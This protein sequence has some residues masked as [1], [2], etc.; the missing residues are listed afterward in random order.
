MDSYQD[1]VHKFK[2]A[3]S[4]KAYSDL[5]NLFKEGQ[6]YFAIVSLEHRESAVHSIFDRR[7]GLLYFLGDELASQRT[8]NRSSRKHVDDSLKE[9]FHFLKFFIQNF[10]TTPHF[11]Q[12]I[13]QIKEVCHSGLRVK[14]VRYIQKAACE[15]L[16]QLIELFEGHHDLKLTE[17]VEEFKNITRYDQEERALILCLFGKIVKHSVLPPKSRLLVFHLY[18]EA[19][20]GVLC[21]RRINMS[22]DTKLPES[23]SAYFKSLADMLD[24][25][26]LP[27]RRKEELVKKL[28]Y[29]IKRVIALDEAVREQQGNKHRVVMKSA[30]DLFARHMNLFRDL[31]Y[32]DHKY[33]HNT[34]RSLSRETTECGEY[35]RRALKRFYRIIGQIL[36]GQN[37]EDS[38]CVLLDFMEHFQ[39]EFKNTNLDLTT[40]QSVVYGFSQMAAPCKVHMEQLNV[41]HMYSIITSYA[42]PLCSSENSHSTHIESVCFYQKALSEILCHMTDV[43]IEKINVLI[44]LSNYTIKRFPDLT[45]NNA[46][47]VSSLITIISNLATVSKGLLQRYLDSIV[48][49]GIA[50]S[51]SHTLALDA[52][53]QRELNNLRESPVCYKNYLSLWTEL[54]NAGRYREHEQLAQYVANTMTDVCIALINRLNIQVKRKDEDTVLSD[55][56]LTQSAVNQADFR[57]FANLVD[58]YVDVVDATKPQLFADT[59]HRF[60]YEAVRLSY[61]YPLIS[62]FYKLIRAGMKIFA[63]WEGEEQQEGEEKTA[64]TRQTEELLSKYLWHTLDLVPAFSNELLIACLYLILNAPFAYV[65]GTLSRTL[66]AFKIAFT[67]GLGNLELAYNALTTLETWTTVQKEKR[68]EQTN[69]LLRE[70][71]AYLEPYLRSTE[72][73]VE[74]SQDLMMTRRRVRRVDI[75]DTECT[76]RNFQRRVL[77]FLGSLDH[78]LFTSF[79]HERASH[80]TGATWDRKN[81]LKF[82]LPLPDVRLVIYFDRMLPRIIALARDSSDRRTKIAA[83]EVLHSVVIIFVGSP[84]LVDHYAALCDTL[85]RAVLVLGCD[86]DEVVCGLFHPLA[87]QLMHW[88]SSRN[89]SMATVIDSL[90]DGLTDNSNPA[91]REFSGM[92]LAEFT[93]WTMRQDR[94]AKHVLDIIKR[95]NRLALHPSTRKRVAAA[96][97]FNHLYVILRENDETVSK[98]WLEIFYCFV[99]SLDGYNDPSISN[100]LA[101]IEKVMIFKAELLN[102]TTESNRRKPPE[103]DE[104]TLTCALYWLL[105]RC[106][107]L[108]E[109]C[110]TKCMEL[111][112]N[113]SRHVDGSEQETTQNFVKTYGMN[114]LN[115]I[116]LKGAELGAEDISMISNVTPLLKALD[117]YVWLIDR[118][119]FPV[120]SLFPSDNVDKQAIFL[121]IRSFA[122]QFWR[123]IA[124]SSAATMNSRELEQLQTL[125][126]KVLMT[127]LNFIQVLLNININILPGSL[128]DE[129][130][131][132]LTIKCIMHPRMVGF[133]MKNIEMTDKLPRVLETL[134]NSMRSKYNALPDIFKNCLLSST[135]EYIAKLLDLNDIAQKDTCDDLTQ[136]VNGL[137]LLK[138]CDMLD[139][140]VVRASAFMSGEK[141]VLQIFRFLVS[142]R[143]G[144][145]TCRDL[146]ARMIGYLRALMEFQFS[147]LSWTIDWPVVVPDDTR[148]MSDVLVNLMSDNTPVTSVDCT[149]ITHGEHFLNTFKS[150]IFEF[151]L[152]RVGAIT[153]IFEN[154]L[155]DNLSLLL[156][157]TEDLLLFLK[158]HRRE[159]RAHVD[160]DT[161]V[162]AILQQFTHLRNTVFN[163][164]SR[165]ERLISI[166]SIVVHLKSTPTEVTQN[167]EFYQW[168]RD[169]LAENYGLEHKTK[170]LKNFFVCLTDV[171]NR[172][173]L[174]ISLRNLKNDGRSLCSNLSETSVN[175]M[176]VIDCFETLLVLLSTTKS[177]VLLECVIHFAAGAG[178]RL[179]DEKLEEHLRGYYCGASHKHVVESLQQTYDAFK[180]GNRW[181]ETERLDILHG[182]LLPAFKVCDAVAI[183]HFFK[184]N[185]QGLVQ[186]ADLPIDDNDDAIKQKIVSKIG[187]FQLLAIMFARVDE[188]RIDANGTTAQSSQG[189]VLLNK[190]FYKRLCQSATNVRS[191]RITRPECKELVR[192]LHCFAYNCSLAAVSLMKKE[193]FYNIFAFG[194]DKERRLWENIIDCSTQY[195]LGQIF[196]ENPKTREITVNIKSADAAD[197]QRMHRYTH[198]Y[199][200]DLSS[201]TLSEDINAYDFNKCVILPADFRSRAPLNSTGS[202]PSCTHGATSIALESNDF[203]EHECMPYICVLL[204]HMKNTFEVNP[205]NPP[206][207][208]KLFLK[209]MQR[210]NQNIQLFMLTII[211]NTEEVFKPYAKAVLTEI[212]A[213]VADYLKRYDLNY[214]ITDVLER[215]LGWHDVAVPSNDGKAA[216]QRLFEVFVERALMTRG[217]DRRVYNYNISLIKLMVEKWCSC[218]RVSTEFL[219]EK[220]E[221]AGA[222]HLI[223]VLLDNDTTGEIVAKDD[224]VHSLLTSLG[225]WNAPEKDETPLQCCECLGLYLRSLDSDRCDEAERENKKCEVKRK[226]FDI[227][228]NAPTS[229]S[230]TYI[231]KQV[232]RVVVLCRIYPEVAKDYIDVAVTGMDKNEQTSFCLEIFALAIPRLSAEEIASNLRRINLEK[233]LTNRRLPHGEKMALQIVRDMVATVSPTDLLRYVNL[234]VPYLKDSTTQ[235]RELVYDLLMRTH[236]RY[237]ADIAVD[238]DATVQDLLFI[239]VRNLLA[240]L[241]D[242]SPDLQDKILKFWTEETSLSTTNSK[243]RLVKLLAMLSS[244]M[245]TEADAFA[246]FVTLLMLQL[247]AGSMEYTKN[248]FDRPVQD[249]CTFEEYKIPVSWRQRNLSCVT[250]M[251]VD[252]LASQMSYS[253]FSQSDDLHGTN[254]APTFSY[255][256]LFHGVP[257]RSL[258]A[259]QEL[260]F[261]PTLDD[262]DD[263]DDAANA[264]TTLDISRDTEFDWTKIASSSRGPLQTPAGHRRVFRI[265]ANTSDVGNVHRHRKIRE[266]VQRAERIKQENIRQRSSVKLNRIGDFPDIEISHA[267]VIVSLQQLIKLDRL[268]CKDVTVILLDSL[269]KETKEMERPDFRRTIVESLQ[270]ILHDLCERD[271][272]FNAVILET[273]L[274]LSRDAPIVDCDPRDIV[275]TSKVNHLDAHGVLL[276]ERSLLPDA[277]DDVSSPTSSKRMRRH[278]DDIRNEN[279]RKWAQ[280]TSLYK[281]LNDV[282]VVLSIFRGQQS[283]GQDVQEAALAEVDGDWIR[284]KKAF[285]NAY[286]GTQD[287]SIKE[288]CLQGLLEAETN[289]CDWSAI[290]RLVKSRTQ[291]GNLSNMW[292]DPWRD[293]VIPYACDA[294]V[295]MSEMDIRAVSNDDTETIESW[296]YDRDKLQHLMPTTGENLV[297][298]QL[299]KDVKKATDLLNE[300]LD[301]TGKQWVELSPLCTELRLRKLFKLQ[302]MSDLD[303]SLKVLRLLANK[304]E[305]KTE[306]KTLLNFW[307]MKAPGIRDNLVQWNKLAANRGYSSM[308]F[309]DSCRKR[310]IKKRLCQINYQLQLGI[311]DAALNQ[312]HRYVAEKHLNRAIKYLDYISEV[313]SEENVR[314]LKLS[315]AWLEARIKCLCADV[316]TSVFKK[317]SC[318]TASWESLHELLK[319]DELDANTSTAIKEH[320]GTMASKIEFL[321]RENDAF[322]SELARSATILRDIGMT[323]TDLNDIREHLLRYSLNNL[324]SCC[325]DAT[326]ANVGE[327]Y[328]AL[329]RH[330]YGRLT[331]TDAESDE[332]FQEF[333]LSTLRSMSHDYLEATHYF[334]CLLRPE[335]LRDDEMRETF[336]RECAKLRPWLFLRWR[337]LLFSHLAT[338]SIATAIV[339]I[340]ERLAET[341]PDAIAY[342]YHL[343][344]EKNPGILHD[345]KFQRI[346]SLLRDKAEEYGL[347]VQAIRYVAQPKL[348]LRYYL[349]EAMRDLSRGKTIESTVES[350]LRKAYPDSGVARGRSPQPGNIFNTIAKYKRMIEALNP[351]DRDIARKEIQELKKSTLDKS[352]KHYSVNNYQTLKDYS[353]FLHEYSGGI[354]IPGQY[355]GDREPMPRRHVRLARFETRVEVMQSLRKPIRIGMVGDNG[356][357]YKF[358]VKFGEDLTID[359]GLQQLYSTMNRT[360]RNDPGCGQRR[361]AIDTYEVIPLSSSFGLIQWIEDTR[362]LADLINFTLSDREIDQC[363]IVHKKYVRWMEGASTKRIADADAY[364]AAVSKYNQQEVTETMKKLIKNTRK[365][366]LRDAFDVI[367]PSPEC[368]VT[369]RRNFVASYA[370]M[371]AAHWLAGVGDRH[372][373][374]TLVHVAT[375][376][377]L[378][379]DFGHAFGSG[380]RA[381]IPELVPFR[382]TPQILELLQPF[383]ERDLLA[384]I[385]THAMRALRDD[386]GPILACMDIFV[387][388]PTYR[389]FNINDAEMTR[390]DDENIDA[391]LKWSS[392]RNI[393]IVAKKLNGIHPSIITLE[394]LKEA[395]NN[396]YFARYDA[397]VAGNDGLKQSRAN[398]RRD[399]LTP[400]E[401]VD[402]LLDQAKDYNILGRMYANWKPWL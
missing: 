44:K 375:G 205:V 247:A 177:M 67:V 192:L 215:L 31:L 172:Q 181:T 190:E 373:E 320:I 24:N 310:K 100:A 377:C 360:L 288:H 88:L 212:I 186:D 33:W 264:S 269:I 185:V 93:R 287:L 220:L 86:P 328:C 386:R 55:V 158:R 128:W 294:F 77:L 316:E 397:I 39:Q 362:S 71:I 365:T 228:A 133:N 49:D 50:W 395:H 319:R 68:D 10:Y 334:P 109:H 196:K 27:D 1:F 84:W 331:S 363:K 125:Q 347:F 78:D 42:L 332:M 102:M 237:S 9:A 52:E 53:L 81:L 279:T 307:L 139:Q 131:S 216:A 272:S 166:Y 183:E 91:L 223:L 122:C 378:G 162:D 15:A 369:L 257:R 210:N 182:F 295:H 399:R 239:S 221:S 62:G 156:E 179:F 115:D 311:V 321:S 184:S 309:Q 277:H 268:I 385:M 392:K 14:G 246:P 226:I 259:T 256:R 248:I 306:M 188:G 344:V 23:F 260:Q 8:D 6:G 37:N 251:F 189:Q 150:V 351:N 383:T 244:R 103:F 134:L 191:I 348:Y 352:S 114:R 366:A 232:K 299:R 148:S 124:E 140:T 19:F 270:R 283:F 127:M 371:C 236:K 372:L 292:D 146:S 119:L 35:G 120:E 83:C 4:D 201:C 38:K 97:A 388:K 11:V 262:D 63:S 54:L 389:P 169:Q 112:V 317:I 57:V 202:D 70:I 318:Y 61:R 47:A 249:S 367:S 25:A 80:S 111:Y 110:R 187:C 297:I 346:R 324:R 104:A 82:N 144:E 345:E 218:L 374:N 304:A 159:L 28:Y 174:R 400:A 381:P 32:P 69:E 121:C 59:V 364:K 195:R 303:A 151:I 206:R 95:I 92:C 301:I 329:A 7:D 3:V 312:K 21:S 336:V 126:C 245:T 12:Y 314:H 337:D 113:I 255:S 402:C 17:T 34:L 64:E 355:T 293:W 353:P 290:D 36:A 208:L 326:A 241:L 278:D 106:G 2:K 325:E 323:S 342:T 274:Q 145:L 178:K 135:R 147:L 267:S 229:S 29:W 234:T 164:D 217:S 101:H 16:Q 138:R 254:M 231:I 213:V 87:L 380:I 280:L 171:A 376:R 107:T 291:N 193:N 252:S 173:D 5:S 163:V 335:R 261:E 149:M 296:T 13:Q 233:I 330:C 339:S 94:Q 224:V 240:G 305:Y 116:I 384:T 322:A 198:V 315:L 48:Y 370:T 26:E 343:T 338:P 207:W 56:A 65:E 350:L 333:L 243:D 219:N 129:S 203:N 382:L 349:D 286:E 45:S 327:H 157:W 130:L 308:L 284:A 298:F 282:D 230:S 161:V 18:T 141:V 276:L 214:V 222:V 359:R 393:E 170:I 238:D 263:G 253:T 98:Y 194:E 275:K 105:S 153:I 43:T 73:S 143:I 391:D 142:E 266:N 358:L 22:N 136:H 357:E 20:N 204:R 175:A 96:V 354:E 89:T 211:S 79:V 356:R 396:E 225:D 41:R 72:S 117:C 51:C 379:I 340:V 85:C 199:S 30:I 160:V 176:K 390:D 271:S 242:P 265:L 108:D 285:A 137:L 273:L 200:Y 313:V 387:H 361:L 58:L 46:L 227:L 209:V 74:I 90:F 66:P 154:M 289:L 168:I 250:P 132:A 258:C 118:Q 40:L 167:D 398:V 165:K 302:I 235:N 281:S 60:L 155:H 152:T 180:D 197:G 368:F 401:Q 123:V 75:I 76:L 341:Y 394:Q 99:H 300:L